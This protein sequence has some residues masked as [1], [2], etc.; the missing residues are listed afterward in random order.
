MQILAALANWDV[1]F[2]KSVYRRIIIEPL[3]H[4]HL[5]W[6]IKERVL[7]SSDKGTCH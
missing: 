6:P 2:G 7:Q 5:G 1:R 4:D 3:N